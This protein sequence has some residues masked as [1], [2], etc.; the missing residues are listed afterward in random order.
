VN[1]EQL[2]RR[3][4]DEFG[5]DRLY[6]CVLNKY[7]YIIKSD[8]IPVCHLVRAVLLFLNPNKGVFQ[9]LLISPAGLVAKFEL[10]DGV[11]DWKNAEALNAA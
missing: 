3:V 7:S 9:R 10:H 4:V 5:R 2:Y 6:R 1:L 8:S 11:P